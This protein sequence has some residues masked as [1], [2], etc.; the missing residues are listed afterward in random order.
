MEQVTISLSPDIKAHGE[1]ILAKTGLTWTDLLE[2]AISLRQPN[3]DSL[4]A[5]AEVEEMIRTGNYGKT[6]TD[7]DLM[8][9]EILQG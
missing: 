1:E 6:Y 7:V 3:E 8:M 9:R 4:E 5:L 2:E